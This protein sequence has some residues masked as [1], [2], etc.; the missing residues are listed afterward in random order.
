[1]ARLRIFIA[2]QHEVVR[3]GLKA[4]LQAEK[5][6]EVAGEGGE[7]RTL[8]RLI[9]AAAPDLVVIDLATIGI[10]TMDTL[11]QALGKLPG[12]KVLVFTAHEETSLIR[13]LLKAGVAGYLLKR[14]TGAEV[15]QALRSIAR[16]GTYIDSRIAGHLFDNLTVRGSREVLTDREFTAIRMIARGFTVKEVSQTLRLSAKTIETYKVRAMKKL[17]VTGRVE[18]VRLAAQ[19]GWLVDGP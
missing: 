15:L 3:G 2:D 6:L 4:L 9:E 18:L 1:M 13:H 19:R 5:D 17:G 10:D 8:P 11:L 16:G 14:C 12:L 7:S